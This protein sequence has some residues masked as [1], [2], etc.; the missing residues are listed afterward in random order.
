MPSLPNSALPVADADAAHWLYMLCWA[1][2]AI[3]LLLVAIQ[4]TLDD[5][6]AQIGLVAA[7]VH[8]QRI[9]ATG[10]DPVPAPPPVAP[11]A[12]LDPAPAPAPAPDPTTDPAPVVP[13]PAT[14]FQ[15][16][17]HRTM[18]NEAR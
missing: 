18:K 12:P 9:R 4:I 14:A 17:Q 8:W 6:A 16:S 1:L 13:A 5:I 10:T 15:H 2:V 7:S 3:G 11:V